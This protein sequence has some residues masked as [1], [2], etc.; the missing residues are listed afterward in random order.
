L[1]GLIDGDGYFYST[2]SGRVVSF[3]ITIDNR[4]KMTLNEIKERFGGNIYL[5]KNSNDS[6]YM[7]TNKK[8][9]IILIHVINGLIRN[10]VR[11]EQMNKL[12][13]RYEIE[14]KQPV[15]LTFNSGWFSGFIDSDGSVYFNEVSGQVFIGISQKKVNLLE[16]LV[17]LYGG[18][19]NPLSQKIGAFKYVVYK[20][21][22]LFNLIDNYFSIYPL[23]TLK[24]ERVKLIKQF[25]IARLDRNS[26]NPNNE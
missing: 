15:P 8:G 14:L 24:L 11:L 9:L 22:D 4:D 13:I 1:A 23:K 10:P 19:L 17:S 3:S 12:C 20:K 5:L 16:P 7:L 2:E 25:Y 6:R 26:S 18:K 21:N